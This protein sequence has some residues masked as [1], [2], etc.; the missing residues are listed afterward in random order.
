MNTSVLRVA[1]GQF[2]VQPE[3]S[4][5]LAIVRDLIDRA[6]EGGAGL[7]VLPEG[8]IARKPGDNTWPVTH[9]EPIDG[10]FVTGLLK[11]TA[12]RPLRSFARRRLLFRTK[13]GTPTTFWSFGT[14]RFSFATR[15]FIC[16]MR[17][18]P[19]KASMPL[20]ATSFRL[21]WMS[22]PSDAAL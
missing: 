3:S 6:Q 12:V 5:N 13:V 11:A 7:L 20:P 19:R 22:D 1:L 8:I 17:L 10:P 18:M 15:N 9:R 16:T 2:F 14:E 21:S 4:T